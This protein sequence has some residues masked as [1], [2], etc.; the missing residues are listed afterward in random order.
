MKQM[1]MRDVYKICIR[2]LKNL[3]KEHPNKAFTNKQG[4]HAS[5]S[6]VIGAM[7][8][9]VDWLYPG[10]STRDVSL[11]VRCHK[12]EHYNRKK[13]VCKRTGTPR[14]PE[15]F[16]KE[17]EEPLPSELMKQLNSM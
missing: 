5:I 2:V 10:L 3:Q 1:G 17:G 12:C 9:H 15:F 16:C 4:E 6:D 13:K 8:Q 7:E 11:V 14:D